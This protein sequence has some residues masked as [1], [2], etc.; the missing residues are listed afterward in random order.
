MN[1]INRRGFLSTSIAAVASTPLLMGHSWAKE[2]LM[3]ASPMDE[4]AYCPSLKALWET[5][6]EKDEAILARSTFTEEEK[7]AFRYPRYEH[8]YVCLATGYEMI[9][10]RFHDEYVFVSSCVTPIEHCQ[11]RLEE[12]VRRRNGEKPQLPDH[13]LFH[14]HALKGTLPNA[15]G[16]LAYY[17]QVEAVIGLLVVAPAHGVVQLRRMFRS[18]YDEGV[19]PVRA[20]LRP[21][22]RE[23]M[24][25]KEI[26]EICK[27]IHAHLPHARFYSCHSAIVA[28]AARRH[29]AMIS[30]GRTRQP[31]P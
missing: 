17:E 24:S 29:A 13:P 14:L 18:S 23:Q 28:A 7:N 20:S 21:K 11:D 4:G 9:K 31:K 22:Y 2:K 6:M 30:S 27:A 26:E 16:V 15:Y 5:F 8:H 10:P 12:Y 1:T 19:E 25:D 3:K